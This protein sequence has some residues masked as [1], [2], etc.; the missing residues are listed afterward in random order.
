MTGLAG[1]CCCPPSSSQKDWQPQCPGKHEHGELCTEIGKINSKKYCS[2]YE[3]CHVI[4]E[5][6]TVSCLVI[7][8]LFTVPYLMAWSFH[9]RFVA[10]HTKLYSVLFPLSQKACISF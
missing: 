8:A 9:I 3:R 4:G 5:K 10:W 7:E 2:F 6:R 1:D